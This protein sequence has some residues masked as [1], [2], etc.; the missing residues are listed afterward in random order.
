MRRR[1]RRPRPAFHYVR[2]RG[3]DCTSRTKTNASDT[4]KGS[5]RRKTEEEELNCERKKEG[6]RDATMKMNQSERIKTAAAA[7]ECVWKKEKEDTSEGI[8]CLTNC[9][10]FQLSKTGWY[11]VHV[12]CQ[13]STSGLRLPKINLIP[14][15]SLYVGSRLLLLYAAHDFCLA[16]SR[17]LGVAGPSLFLSSYLVVSWL[18]AKCNLRE[19]SFPSV[20]PSFQLIKIDNGNSYGWATKER[21]SESVSRSWPRLECKSHLMLMRVGMK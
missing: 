7:G 20:A 3:E 14:T 1:R 18:S 10:R 19:R 2:K 21:A 6:L 17:F 16:K 12:H 8:F 4:N 5:S 9:S 11:S 15:G 13:M